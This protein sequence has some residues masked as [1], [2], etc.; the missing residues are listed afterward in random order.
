MDGRDCPGVPGI[1]SPAHEAG[2]HGGLSMM[3]AAQ[4]QSNAGIAGSANLNTLRLNSM[5]PR[6]C[7][8]YHPPAKT[9]L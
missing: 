9:V 6:F 2:G 7:A 5:L 3:S 1:R 4:A 8:A